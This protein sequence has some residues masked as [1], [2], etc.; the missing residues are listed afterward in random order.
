MPCFT[1]GKNGTYSGAGVLGL[2]ASGCLFHDNG[3]CIGGGCLGVDVLGLM[4]PCTSD[5][6]IISV[7]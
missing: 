2:L 5:I 6:G 1:S 3:V 7:A 4:T